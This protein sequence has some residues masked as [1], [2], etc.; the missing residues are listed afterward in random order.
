MAIFGLLCADFWQTGLFFSH[1]KL[2]NRGF[3]RPASLHLIL[4]EHYL[5]PDLAN[6]GRQSRHLRQN[7]PDGFSKRAFGL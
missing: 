1:A 6:S 4:T 5:F 3:N 7:Y 2:F